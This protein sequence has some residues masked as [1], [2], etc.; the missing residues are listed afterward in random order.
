MKKIFI[1]ILVVLMVFTGCSGTTDTVQMPVE[2]SENTV[3]QEYSIF[4]EQG[5]IHE[6]K[7]D[8]ADTDFQNILE[9]PLDEEY[10]PA[11]ITLDGIVVDDVGFR[12]KG[13]STLRDVAGSDSERYS[14][15]FKVD[16]YLDQ[17]LLGLDEF[18]INNMFSD[19]SYLREYISYKAMA[20]NGLDVPLS[21]FVNVYI[22]DELYGLYLLVES[23]DDSFLERNFGS[24]NGNLYRADIGTSLAI[25]DGKYIENTDQKNG[26]DE[27]KAD[28]YN[29]M[30]VLNGMPDGEKGDIETVLDVESALRY[31]ATNTLLEN[32]DSLNGQHEQNYYLYNDNGIF[33]VIPWDYNM[34]FGSFGGSG[35]STVDIDNPISGTPTAS[36]LIENLLEVDEYRVLYYEILEEYIDY[37]SDFETQVTT[38][39][40]LIRESVEN[41]PTKFTTMEN[42]ESSVVYQEGGEVEVASMGDRGSD[43]SKD[44]PKDF[45]GAP[46]AGGMENPKGIQGNQQDRGKSMSNGNG[47]S[48]INVLMARIENVKT[49]LQ[50]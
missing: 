17:D 12:T 27:S 13:N 15:K 25:V 42:F 26:E 3:D 41:D 8:I 7:I 33:V 22:N 43:F 31:I 9:N 50:N 36:P 6:I 16:E 23:V 4:F 11:T 48:I 37:F 20:D 1:L 10:H 44:M 35:Q 14:F 18:V 24:N 5:E 46:P 21:S 47:I 38:L 39:S 19:S 49:Q 40:T 2:T 30:D 32:Y 45:Q 34:S 28:L 29:F